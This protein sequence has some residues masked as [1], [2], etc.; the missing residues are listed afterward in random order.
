[1]VIPV[2]VTVDALRRRIVLRYGSV[3][4]IREWTAL[5]DRALADPAWRPGFDVM[6]VRLNSKEPVPS[7]FIQALAQYVHDRPQFRH[8]RWVGVVDKPAPYG[9]G[10]MFEAMV[11]D[12]PIETAVFDDLAQA[13]AWLARPRGAAASG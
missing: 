8:M 7:S 1:M 12:L 2:D 9:M 3:M 4:P 13:E 6:I 10:R 11:S 5:M